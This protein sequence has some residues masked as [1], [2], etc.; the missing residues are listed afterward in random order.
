MTMAARMAK[1]KVDSREHLAL[2]NLQRW[3]AVGQQYDANCPAVYGLRAHL[4][5]STAWSGRDRRQA[6]GSGLPQAPAISLLVNTNR[7]YA[8]IFYLLI[9]PCCQLTAPCRRRWVTVRPRT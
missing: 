9:Y 5:A 7:C 3:C 1:R 4:P 6:G 2:A 8:S